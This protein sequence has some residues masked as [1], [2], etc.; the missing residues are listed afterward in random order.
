MP[1]WHFDDRYTQ[2]SSACSNY[3]KARLRQCNA[4]GSIWQLTPQSASWDVLRSRRHRAAVIIGCIQYKLLVLTLTAL[5][6]WINAGLSRF[7]DLA[8]YAALRSTV[9]WPWSGHCPG[10]LLWQYARVDIHCLVSDG[11]ALFLSDMGDM[12]AKKK[13]RIALTHIC[14]W[15]TSVLMKFGVLDYD[16][17][18]M[19]PTNV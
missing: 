9:H 4:V 12:I 5:H 10:A 15:S 8:G 3:V 18:F 17:E 14:I 2:V 7:T 19:F 1:T 11:D 6:E 13:Q 16:D